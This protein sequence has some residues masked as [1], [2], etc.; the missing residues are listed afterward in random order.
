[1]ATAVIKESR[2]HIRCDKRARQLL[3]KAATYE[4][5][6][7]SEFVLSN[8]LASAEQVVQAHESITLSSRDFQLFLSV[9]DRPPK[10]NAALKRA[11]KRH[12]ANAGR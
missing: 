4:R 11:F 10:P 5:V 1:M 8:A 2:L 9:L 12:S 3:D 6:S 7:V